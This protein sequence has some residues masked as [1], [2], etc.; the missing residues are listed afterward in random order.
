MYLIGRN[1]R[2]N[3]AGLDRETFSRLLGGENSFH[4]K[5][6]LENLDS[7]RVG[8]IKL[9]VR[10][11]YSLRFKRNCTFYGK[12]NLENLLQENPEDNRGRIN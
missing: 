1:F 12:Y 6:D 9:N 4:T 2:S 3:Y 11:L 10:K 5:E 7:K 8:G